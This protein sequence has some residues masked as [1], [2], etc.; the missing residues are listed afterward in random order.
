MSQKLDEEWLRGRA[1]LGAAAKWT[2]EEIRLVAELGY[3]LAEQGRCQEAIAIFEGLA[4]VAPAAAYFQSA[5][6]ALR[7]R[8]GELD[9][10]LAHLN[11]ALEADPN[12]ISALTNRGEALLRMGQEREAAIDLQKVLRLS[13]DST[14]D[15]FLIRARAL[16]TQIEQQ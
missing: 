6:G 7:L 15:S 14:S 5:L 1:S 8:I 4:A 13:D 3:G 9:A 2:P 16:L 10:A 12:E 11:A